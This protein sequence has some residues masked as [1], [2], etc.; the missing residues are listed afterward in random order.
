MIKPEKKIIYHEK[1]KDSLFKT[2]HATD[3]VT[4]IFVHSG[5]GSIV[6]SEKSYPFKSGT[7]CLIGHGKYHYTM[8][9]DPSVYDRSKIFI[10]RD[11]FEK[12]TAFFP[13]NKLNNMQDKSFV[14]SPVP[15]LILPDVENIF[16]KIFD[17]DKNYEDFMFTAAAI[18]LLILL[19]K[20]STDDII[21][22]HGIMNKAIEY[23]NQN[24]FKEITIDEICNF[25]HISKYY[26]CRQFK[27]NTGMTVM[28]YILKTRITL[29]KDML[30]NHN[31]SITDVSMKCGF[32]SVSYFCRVFK[33]D[34]GI[35]PLKFKK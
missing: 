6:C 1:G 16:K 4:I 7:L 2:W 30:L 11:I 22:S 10:P 35:T 27:K 19:D 8:P 9:D 23:I 14:Y 32:S 26:F 24:I 25:L 17:I 3:A 34:T 21:L 18:E 13:K 28:N 31:L 20:F 33:A 5:S 29:A 12:I 15:S